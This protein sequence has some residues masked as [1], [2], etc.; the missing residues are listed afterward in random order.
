[1]SRSLIAP[2]VEMIQGDPGQKVVLTVLHEGS[3][4]PVDI[5]LVRAEIHVDSI[6]GDQR[7]QDKLEEWDFMLDRAT[8]IAYVPARG[9]NEH[10]L[11]DAVRM[12]MERDHVLS[13]LIQP[14]ART[15]GAAN[16][17]SPGFHLVQLAAFIARTPAAG[18]P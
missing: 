8:Q 18:V 12:L 16:P 17:Y 11:G 14:V 6:L 2:A 1:M 7:R 4:K 10:Q 15:G 9:V 5:P 3:K 13:L